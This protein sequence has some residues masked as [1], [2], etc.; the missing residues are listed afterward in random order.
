VHFSCVSPLQ[1]KQTL[2]HTPK[3]TPTRNF[4]RR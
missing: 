2:Y 1:Q 3:P 4:A